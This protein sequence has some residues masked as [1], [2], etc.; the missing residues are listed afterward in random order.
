MSL[1]VSACVSRFL[2]LTSLRR[3]ADILEID[4][5]ELILMMIATFGQA[6]AGHAPA[7]SI[8]G[9]LVTWRFLVSVSS[10]ALAPSGTH[11]PLLD[12]RRYWW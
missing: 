2:S 9:V 4:G 5:L 8:I 10:D 7:V 3:G 12:G 11:T 1:A 6:V